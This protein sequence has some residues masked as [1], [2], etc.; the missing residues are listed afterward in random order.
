MDPV[1][2]RP[3]D[4][5]RIKT[6]MAIA[7]HYRDSAAR[8]DAELHHLLDLRYDIHPQTE[9]WTVDLATGIFTRMD[10]PTEGDPM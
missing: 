6:L 4:L 5:E 10:T 7:Q 2:V 8:V 3:A 1:T 9:Q